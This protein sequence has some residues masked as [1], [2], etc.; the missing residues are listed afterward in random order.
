MQV[1][2]CDMI[3]HICSCKLPFVFG[4]TS[5]L[6]QPVALCS[7][8]P[9]VQR[10]CGAASAPQ[11]R[12]PWRCGSSRTLIVLWQCRSCWGAWGRVQVKQGRT[13]R[14][15]FSQLLRI[16]PAAGCFVLG[17]LCFFWKGCCR[18]LDNGFGTEYAS[19]KN[20]GWSTCLQTKLHQRRPTT[21]LSD[22]PYRVWKLGMRREGR[23][24]LLFHFAQFVPYDKSPAYDITTFV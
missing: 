2:W 7:P 21:H 17:A 5:N 15:K 24:W 23:G 8:H 3:C 11:Q 6:G 19:N 12:C 20:Q 18:K 10:R 1:W 9:A 14:K 13:A 16:I 22:C 4:A